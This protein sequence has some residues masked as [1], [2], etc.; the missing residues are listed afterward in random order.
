MT[1]FKNR[2]IL[3]RLAA[4]DGRLQRIEARIE[5]LAATAATR[6]E[7]DDAREQ[8]DTLARHG[9]RA[10]E[11]LDAARRELARRADGGP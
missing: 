3:E 8:A 6:A 11:L 4:L 10:I 5:E 9:L 2:E 7:V 1:P